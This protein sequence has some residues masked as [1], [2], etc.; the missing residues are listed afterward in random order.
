MPGPSGGRRPGHRAVSQVG[1]ASIPRGRKGKAL[2]VVPKPS[3]TSSV[4]AKLPAKSKGPQGASVEA[5]IDSGISLGG[6]TIRTASTLSLDNMPDPVCPSSKKVSISSTGKLYHVQNPTSAGV[7][8]I[9]LESQEAAGAQQL[10]TKANPIPSEATATVSSDGAPVVT[11]ILVS[12][13]Q[14][15]DLIP[16]DASR[17]SSPICIVSIS[18]T[19]TNWSVYFPTCTETLLRCTFSVHF[20]TAFSAYSRSF[21]YLS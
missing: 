1:P 21:E 10:A 15:V 14:A 3:K 7:A 18:S 4:K 19:G 17:M 12:V 5:D 2:P 16:V 6:D 11:G 9:G 20:L 13:R 8:E